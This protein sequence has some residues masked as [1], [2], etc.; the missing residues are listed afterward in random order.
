M[1]CMCR[2]ARII[3]GRM[4]CNVR[5]SMMTDMGATEVPNIP[6]ACKPVAERLIIFVCAARQQHLDG[7]NTATTTASVHLVGVV[8]GIQLTLLMWRIANELPMRRATVSF[9]QVR[10]MLQHGVV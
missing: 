10:R 5:P 2:H 1:V 4:A 9:T 8:M 3:V 7:A 6:T